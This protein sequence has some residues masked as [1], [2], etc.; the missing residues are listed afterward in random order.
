MSEQPYFKP[1]NGKKPS[2]K[3][4]KLKTITFNVPEEFYNEFCEYCEKNNLTKL[5][6]IT[7]FLKNGMK[8]NDESCL[9][10]KL[11]TGEIKKACTQIGYKVAGIEL[12]IE[13]I[14]KAVEG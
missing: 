8:I 3:K 12:Q 7:H 4:E 2:F 1:S 6:L 13:K 14:L 9:K 11:M 5:N 10:T